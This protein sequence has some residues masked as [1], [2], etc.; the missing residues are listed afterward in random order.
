VM[1]KLFIAHAFEDKAPFV[2][3]LALKLRK[4]FEIWFEEFSLNLGDNLAAK[5]GGGLRA[6][7]F[8]IVVLSQNFF[9]K[10]WPKAE[11]D[12]LFG[13][14]ERNHKLL[15]PVWLEIDEAHI[16]KFSAAL[17]D[18]T[19]SLESRGMEQVV[20]D[21]K[22][23]VAVSVRTNEIMNPDTTKTSIFRMEKIVRGLELEQK[24]VNSPL[25]ASLFLMTMDR[26]ADLVFE[27]LLFASLPGDKKFTRTPAGKHEAV[28]IQSP[29]GVSVS[30][31]SKNFVANTVKFTTLQMV[32]YGWENGDGKGK[33]RNVILIS[34]Q[35]NLTCL[36]ENELGFK[37]QPHSLPLSA[38]D[39][40]KFII[41]SVCHYVVQYL[42]KDA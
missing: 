10:N 35:W 16:R 18:R 14:E 42:V 33:G 32:I 2:R 17:A 34:E 41:E 40:A 1:T 3:P 25:G 9:E 4:E 38:D 24:I 5:I 21:I 26:I 30:I 36:S 22:S 39:I 19:A 31:G 23:A 20:E 27:G 7:D 28:T 11:L 29:F 6:C 15:L 12:A 8:G 13:L 37:S